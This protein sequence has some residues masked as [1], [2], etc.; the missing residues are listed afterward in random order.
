M[1]LAR[2]LTLLAVGTSFMAL[3]AEAK[4]KDKDKKKKKDKDRDERHY[5]QS[6]DYYR[7]Q[8]PGVTIA[9]QPQRRTYY[10]RPSSTV[11]IQQQ[12]PAY[13]ESQR[14]A[15]YDQQRYVEQSGYSSP[16]LGID[17]QRGLARQGYYRGPIDGDIGPGSR[18]AIRAFQADNGF[19]PTGR[20]DRR[21]LEALR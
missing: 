9:V 10:T 4:D 11:V 8:R 12:R 1:H 20:I 19:A 15:Y 7:Q 18:S 14:P 21:L 16:S 2:I 6:D 5:D 3:P 17:V 13:Y